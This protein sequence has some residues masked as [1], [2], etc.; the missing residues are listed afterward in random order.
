MGEKLVIK[1]PLSWRDPVK[2]ES[3][4]QAREIV[5]EWTGKGL[6]MLLDIN[7]CGDNQHRMAEFDPPVPGKINPDGYY[8]R[9]LFVTGNFHQSVRLSYDALKSIILPAEDSRTLR[10]NFN[11]F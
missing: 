1:I 3:V 4:E 9:F 7:R 8:V 11:S 6:V 5:K 2:I 10:G